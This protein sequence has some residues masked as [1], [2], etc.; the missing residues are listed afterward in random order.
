[1]TKAKQALL[2]VGF[3]ILVGVIFFTLTPS[4][5]S[6]PNLLE[7]HIIPVG[8]KLQVLGINENTELAVHNVSQENGETTAQIGIRINGTLTDLQTVKDGDYLEFI[9]LKEKIQVQKV[10]LNK[11]ITKSFVEIAITK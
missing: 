9:E 11:G 7:L 1:M 3:L 2:I 5:T 4:P 8:E 10:S 6:S